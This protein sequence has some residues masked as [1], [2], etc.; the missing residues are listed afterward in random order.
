MLLVQFYALLNFF[1]GKA[2]VYEVVLFC[3]LYKAL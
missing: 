3:I 2:L 1:V